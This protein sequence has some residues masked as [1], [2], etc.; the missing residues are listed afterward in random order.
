MSNELKLK[1]SDQEVKKINL[2]YLQKRP[3]MNY[4]NRSPIFSG[5]F[6]S[7]ALEVEMYCIDTNIKLFYRG[8][9]LTQDD[10]DVFQAI[11]MFY[12]HLSC[13]PTFSISLYQLAKALGK[14]PK[15]NTNKYLISSIERLSLSVL[16]V[17]KEKESAS[18]ALTSYYLNEETGMYDFT[19]NQKFMKLMSFDNYSYQ[20]YEIR[21]NLKGYLTKWF[22]NFYSTHTKKQFHYLETL[23]LTCNSTTKEI[24][25]FKK[26]V[27]KSLDQL[28]KKEIIKSYSL[29]KNKEGKTIC[30]VDVFN[31][32]VND[33][34]IELLTLVNNDIHDEIDTSKEFVLKYKKTPKSKSKISNNVENIEF[35]EEKPFNYSK[36]I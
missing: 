24:R 15:G 29:E 4:I 2:S 12:N 5:S 20:D 19:F 9:T 17:K 21:S 30:H 13:P 23:K 25:D 34:K 8:E 26:Q 16:H 10:Y 18:S 36:Y 35:N 31:K 3:M 27:I 32:P 6:E 7:G 11:L 22:Y 1:D 33:N 14:T 28:L